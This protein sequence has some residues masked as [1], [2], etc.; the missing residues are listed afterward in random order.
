MSL[1]RDL[2]LDKKIFEAK[3][4]VDQFLEDN[5]VEPGSLVQSIEFKHS[6]FN[7]ADQVN[8]FLD[9]HFLSGH[10]IDEDE[11]KKKFSVVLFDEIA[12]IDST[13]KEI[14]LR[15]G[16]III[17]G[18]LKPMTSDNPLLFGDGSKNIKLS[19]D[20][21]YII[22]LARTVTGFH[23]AYGEVKLTKKD[24]LSFKDN[25][26]SGVIGVDLSIDFDHETREAAGWIKEVF[27]SED[28]EALLGGVRWTPKGALSLSDR[29]F[30]YF[31]PEFNLDWVHPHTGKSHGPTLLGGGLVNRPF[32]KMGAIVT[33]KNQGDKIV[34]TIK[35]SEHNAKVSDLDSQITTLKLS[36]ATAVNVISGL[37]TENVKLS[38]ELKTLKS[39]VEKKKKEDEINILFSENK[40][41][42]AQKEAMLSGKTMMEVL[43]LGAELNTDP[44][45]KEGAEGNSAVVK[46]NDAELKLC[47]GLDLTP[48]EFVKFNTE[49]GA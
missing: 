8:D 23:A 34:D 45:G 10:K 41:N 47:K 24:L 46:L 42:K 32:L 7:D 22:E 2:L 15:E 30:R 9:A 36:E 3:E 48:E 18:I 37:K 49:E 43:Q 28:G 4:E 14:K 27:L 11:K 13:I 35:L 39:D 38:D 25:F 17:I 21:P 44:K 20:H 26:E 29:E 31:S 5:D 16:I 33:M 19:A 6:V 12:F 1:L 40:I